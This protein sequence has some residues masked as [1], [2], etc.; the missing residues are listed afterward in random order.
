MNKKRQKKIEKKLDQLSDLLDNITAAQTMDANDSDTWD[1]DALY[2]LV[3]DLKEFTCSNC[4]QPI[5]DHDL[6]Q[7]NYTLGICDYA[8]EINQFHNARNNPVYEVR[9]WLK[10]VEHQSCP[11]E[12]SH[13]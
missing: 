6:T 13:E 8:N 9:L 2:S 10:S 1:S 5:N 4:Q 7:K 11:K 12:V 3:E